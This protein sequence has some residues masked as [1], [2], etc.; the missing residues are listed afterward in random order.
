MVLKKKQTLQIVVRHRALKRFASLKEKSANLPVTVLW[1]RRTGERRTEPGQA[2]GE[3]RRAERRGEPP[4]TWTAADF[5]VV[6]P[7]ASSRQSGPEG[8]PLPQHSRQTKKNGRAG[9]AS[10]KKALKKR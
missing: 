7:A 6:D 9:I 8:T 1:D 2:A 3:R 5:V 10:R 4:F